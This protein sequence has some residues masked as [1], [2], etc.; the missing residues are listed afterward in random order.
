MTCFV[1][2]LEK[3][4]YFKSLG[5][6]VTKDNAEEIEREIGRTVGREGEHCPAI[7]KEMKAWLEDPE[8][9]ARLEG[10]LRERFAKG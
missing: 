5:I 7:W 8:K 10:D 6:K 3:K 2:H 9:K 4:G 1:A